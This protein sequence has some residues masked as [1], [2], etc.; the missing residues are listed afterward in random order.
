MAELPYTGP[1]GHM[2]PVF[3]AAI[4]GLSQVFL[5]SQARELSGIQLA[6]PLW[7]PGHTPDTEQPFFRGQVR[8]VLLFRDCLLYLQSIVQA[9]FYRPDLWRYLD[10]VVSVEAARVRLE[11]FSSCCSVY[12]RVDFEATLFD[13]YALQQRGSTNVNFNP[14][15]IQ[16]LSSLRPGQRTVLELGSEFL[17]VSTE[18]GQL[19]EDK[20]KLP[21]RWVKAFLQSQAL[22]RDAQCWQSLSTLAARQFLSRLNGKDGVRHFVTQTRQGLQVLGSRSHRDPVLAVAGLHR[23]ALLKPLI[24]HVQGLKIYSLPSQGTIWVAELP[25]A[26]VTL[27]L[28]ASVKHGFSGE[29][30]ALRSLSSQADVEALDFV[31]QVLPS[32]ESFSL[33]EL[34]QYLE[35]TPQAVLPL[36]DTLA[37]QGLLGYD[38]AAARYFYRPLPFQGLRPQRLQNAQRLE[39]AGAVKLEELERLPE[40]LQ[41]SAWVQG[42]HALYYSSLKLYQG[43]LQSGGCTCQW[44]LTHGLQRGPCKHLLA[45]RFAAE[46]QKVE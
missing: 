3:A 28:S 24:P 18:A 31:R 5:P 38:V 19:K 29:G 16:G 37:M 23:L 35:S 45:L 25:L 21:E 26:R 8:D 6:T 27:A 30:E 2:S 15:F 33:Q 11:C 12:G 41:A 32:L 46:A 44:F 34:A 17:Q 40:G 9:R 7:A 22:W 43:L 4:P 20:V 1:L 13:G 39:M 36:A 42:D 14:D 10:P